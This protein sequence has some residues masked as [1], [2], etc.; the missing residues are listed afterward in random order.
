LWLARIG[1]AYRFKEVRYSERALVAEEILRLMRRAKKTE[2]DIAS[3]IK[4]S[5]SSIYKWSHGKVPVHPVWL[6][7]IRKACG[8]PC[9]KC[10]GSGVIE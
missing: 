9:P 10:K 8:T 2:A 6:D 1:L 7:A 4:V 5:V 3:E